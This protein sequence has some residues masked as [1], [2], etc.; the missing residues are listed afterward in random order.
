MQPVMYPKGK[1][2][3]I[4]SCLT[5]TIVFLEICTYDDKT[6]N[7]DSRCLAEHKVDEYILLIDDRTS[8]EWIKNNIAMCKKTPYVVRTKFEI[9]LLCHM[10]ENYCFVED[11][12]LMSTWKRTFCK[13]VGTYSRIFV[14]DS[15]FKNKFE[16]KDLV[17]HLLHNTIIDV[18]GMLFETKPDPEIT[19]SFNIQ[20]NRVRTKQKSQKDRF[21]TLTKS[22]E[23]T[24]NIEDVETWHDA[25][26]D[27]TMDIPD[28]IVRI[29][30]TFLMIPVCLSVFCLTSYLVRE[31][32]QQMQR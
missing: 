6:E 31:R 26:E 24:E 2:I 12:K 7:H 14:I 28:E 8:K 1:A 30:V 27:I 11:I 16:F 22:I 29:N 18:T 10:F 4:Y 3:T 19:V 23:N 9:D 15:Y 21:E 32:H 25:L 5:D 17:M 20:E 13:E